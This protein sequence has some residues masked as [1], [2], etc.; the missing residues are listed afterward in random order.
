M[1]HRGERWKN[2]QELIGAFVMTHAEKEARRKR[3]I[4]ELRGRVRGIL[5]REDRPLNLPTIEH[6]LNAEDLERDG[7]VG[8]LNTFDVR[9]AIAELIE[10]GEAE[11]TLSLLIQRKADPDSPSSPASRCSRALGDDFGQDEGDLSDAGGDQR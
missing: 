9:D 4:A 10:A 1:G 6:Y 2:G 3:W 5:E 8:Y 11:Y 7:E